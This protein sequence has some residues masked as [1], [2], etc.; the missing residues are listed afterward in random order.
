MVVNGAEGTLPQD[1]YSDTT[2]SASAVAYAQ[3]T[4]YTTTS[5]GNHQGQFKTTGTTT[6]TAT[7]NVTFES[8]KYYTVYLGGSGSSSSV[9]TT[10]D[11]MTAPA[12][13]KARVRFVHLSSAAAASVDLAVTG[14]TKVVSGLAYQTAS[15]YNDVDANTSFTLYAAGSATAVLTIPSTFQAGKI[16]TFLYFRR[17]Y[18]YT[19]FSCNCAKLTSSV[20]G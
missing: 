2:R 6:V 14:G 1:F 12:A 3:N 7:A 4:S 19:F 20:F 10:T 13:G 11:D 18:G 9:V 16:Y 8:G 17:Y 5:A 15:A